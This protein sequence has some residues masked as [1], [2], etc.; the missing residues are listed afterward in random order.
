MPNNQCFHFKLHI[1]VVLLPSGA[2]P[3]RREFVY[4]GQL[5]KSQS[6]SELLESLR[7]QQQELSAAMDQE[8]EEEPEEDKHSQVDHVCPAC[9]PHISKDVQDVFLM[10]IIQVVDFLPC[11]F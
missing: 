7:R 11:P 1:H 8:V 6:R 9:C 4:P 3:Q 10:T 2:T 5:V